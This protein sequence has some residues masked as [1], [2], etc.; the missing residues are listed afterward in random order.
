MT[1]RVPLRRLWRLPG[2]VLLATAALLPAA[3][4]TWAQTP[5]CTY[6]LVETFPHDPDAF[7]QGLLVADGELYESTGLWG[8]S[9]LRRVD[10]QSGQVLQIV[11][12]AGELF[13]EGLSLRGD[14]LVQLTYTN[15]V[16]FVYDRQTLEVLETFSY[17]TQGWGLTTDG[18][19]M[20]MTDGSSTLRFWD[21]LTFA[22]VGQVVVHDEVGPVTRLNELEVIGRHV[23]A[24]V[25]YSDRIARF[26][27]VSGEVT[28]W[29][30]LAG[31]LG[32]GTPPGPLNGIAWDLTTS[33]LLVTGKLWPSLFHIEVEGCVD[34]LVFSDGFEWGSLA[35]WGAPRRPVST[36]ATAD[37]TRQPS[38][39]PAPHPSR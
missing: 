29:V 32:S 18:H 14:Q 13:G 34:T 16:G 8:E 39:D 28:S 37:S 36:A 17:P 38:P 35:S 6:R 19:R 24:N 4:S 27:P 20:L 11:H 12:L 31:I 21:P 3:R 15:H 33:R 7:T 25:L 1:R 26:D 10:L 2:A 23:W 5:V 22:E 9:S 30:D